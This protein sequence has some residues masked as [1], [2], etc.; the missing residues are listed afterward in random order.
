MANM[1][2]FNELAKLMMAT[3]ASPLV[4]GNVEFWIDADG[5]WKD[6]LSYSPDTPKWDTK[7]MGES[8]AQLAKVYPEVSQ[9]VNRTCASFVDVSYITEYGLTQKLSNSI[10]VF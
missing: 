1:N 6:Q 2:L 3:E 4:L 8:V 5:P 9:I 10:R 7:A